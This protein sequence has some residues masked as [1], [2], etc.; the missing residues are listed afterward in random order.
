MKKQIIQELKLYDKKTQDI[1][2]FF[3]NNLQWNILHNTHLLVI[4][5]NNNY[6]KTLIL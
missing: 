4:E 5:D 3:F 2:K 1:F 6:K